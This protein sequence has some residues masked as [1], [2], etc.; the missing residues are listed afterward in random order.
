M[1]NAAEADMPDIEVRE[2]DVPGL[3]EAGI[4]IVIGLVV[5]AVAR[6]LINRLVARAQKGYTFFGGRQLK[7][8]R[9][10]RAKAESQRRTQRADTIGALLR[11]AVTLSV[12]ILTGIMALEAIG[13]N[14][15]PLLASVG[16]LGLALSFGAR[17]MIQDAISGFFITIEDQYG[18][19]DTIEVGEI[20]GTVQS[21][22]IRI[23]RLTDER[24]VVWYVRNGE[25]AKVGNRSQGRYVQPADPEP[26][27]VD[28]AG[29]TASEP[30]AET[31]KDQP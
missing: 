15:A 29:S 26:V 25:I 31:R 12:G 5:L 30:A 13:I 22:G 20:V 11:S 23:T 27:P 21:V 3:I 6:F 18:I 2:F 28:A 8:A 14:I 7:W 10:A 9:P 1:L 19:G 17:E 16:V 24:G 4:I